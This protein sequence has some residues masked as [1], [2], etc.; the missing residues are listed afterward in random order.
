MK[1]KYLYTGPLSGVSLKGEG[2]IMLHPGQIVELP[3]RNYYTERL[4][5][6]GWLKEVEPETKITKKEKA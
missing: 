4:M 6:K 3:E 2:D 5:R 1:K